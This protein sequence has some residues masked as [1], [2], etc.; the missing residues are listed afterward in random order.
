M[1][2]HQ[3]WFA[4]LLNHWFG[5]TI[6]HLLL[7]IGI[8]VQDPANPIRMH[9]AMSVVVFL[10]GIILV[11]LLKPRISVDKPGATQQ[12]AEMLLTLSLIHI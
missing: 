5:P 10:F 9:V 12:I 8:H 6:S 4:A 1:N 7:L 11:M 3:H 2:I